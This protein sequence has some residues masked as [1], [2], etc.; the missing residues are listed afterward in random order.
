MREAD[1]FYPPN[2]TPPS[3]SPPTKISIGIGDTP[4]RPP[5]QMS[6]RVKFYGEGHDRPMMVPYSGIGGDGE[7]LSSE[8]ILEQMNQTEKRFLPDSTSTPYSMQRKSPRTIGP[9]TDDQ[10]TRKRRTQNNSITVDDDVRSGKAARFCTCNDCYAEAAG[11]SSPPGSP[12]KSFLSNSS[13]E[14]GT[15]TSD[16]KSKDTCEKGVSTDF[17]D[18]ALFRELFRKADNG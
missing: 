5:H 11:L 8:S 13:D 17:D 2:A 9:G 1:P 18:G 10:N 15:N 3:M 4:A 16:G 7:P 12:N 6:K 14:K